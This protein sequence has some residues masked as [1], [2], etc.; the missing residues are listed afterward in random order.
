[1]E[2]KGKSSKEEG[3]LWSRLRLGLGQTGVG[4]QARLAYKGT[5]IS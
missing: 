5:S 4:K 3:L 2:H 1:M